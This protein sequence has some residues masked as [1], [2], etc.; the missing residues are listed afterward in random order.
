M[1]GQVVRV[2]YNHIRSNSI[3]G[4]YAPRARL[5]KDDLDMVSALICYC[6]VWLHACPVHFASALGKELEAS[7]ICTHYR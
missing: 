2:A 7:E 4:I 5:L 6:I 1:F 3:P